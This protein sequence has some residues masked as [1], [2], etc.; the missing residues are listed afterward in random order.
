MSIFNWENKHK[1]VA[2]VKGELSSKSRNHAREYT[3]K[4]AQAFWILSQVEGLLQE[5]LIIREYD[6]DCMITMNNIEGKDFRI[7]LLFTD[8]NPEPIA[9][10]IIKDGEE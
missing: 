6:T 2:E 4:M 3:D 9:A 10:R 7:Q 1:K 8:S 5:R